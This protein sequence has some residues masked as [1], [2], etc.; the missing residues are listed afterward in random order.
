MLIAVELYWSTID[1]SVHICVDSSQTILEHYR[2]FIPTTLV[3]QLE[4]K[5]KKKP[6]KTGQPPGI[7]PGAS[8]FGCRCSDHC[9]TATQ[10]ISLQLTCII[11][12]F[13]YTCSLGTLDIHCTKGLSSCRRGHAMYV[14][15]EILDVTKNRFLH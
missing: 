8:C 12:H 6:K 5:R 2:S 9:A 13:I 1:L 3:S 11:H 15:N 4:E 10:V 14:D 7:K